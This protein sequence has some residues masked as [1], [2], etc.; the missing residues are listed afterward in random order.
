[1]HAF[2]YTNCARSAVDWLCPVGHQ[3]GVGTGVQIQCEHA[4]QPQCAQRTRRCFMCVYVCAP[5]NLR[6]PMRRTR[7]VLAPSVHMHIEPQCNTRRR[8]C[9]SACAERCAN[10]CR[11]CTECPE[12]LRKHNT[13]AARARLRKRGA[14]THCGVPRP[15]PSAQFIDK[16]T[17]QLIAQWVAQY[18]A[19]ACLCPLVRRR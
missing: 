14:F 9:A 17:A 16:P 6:A 3:C 18:C 12:A 19:Q 10:S 5:N 7:C 8:D 1:M 15:Q 4:V 2:A 13:H 11:C